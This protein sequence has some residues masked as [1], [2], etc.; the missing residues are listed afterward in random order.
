MITTVLGF[1]KGL[2]WQVYAAVAALALLGGTVWYCDRQ[3][4]DKVEQAEVIGRT[5]ERNEQ[6]EQTIENVKTAEEAREDITET[7][8]AGDLTRYNQCLRTARTPANCERLLPNVP[9]DQ[10]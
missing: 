3:I 5:E 6:L 8:P 4:D 10:R 7:S 9:E 1:F 2:S